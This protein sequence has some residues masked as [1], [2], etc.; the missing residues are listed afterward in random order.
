[1]CYCPK[2]VKTS[3]LRQNCAVQS[4]K[5]LRRTMLFQECA[6]EADAANVTKSAAV[7]SGR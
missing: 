7:E 4:S 6:A 2:P 1:V 5:R 3:G